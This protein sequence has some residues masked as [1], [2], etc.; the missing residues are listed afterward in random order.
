MASQ[1]S[2]SISEHK[3][4]QLKKRLDS[5]HYCHPLTLDSAALAERLLTDLLKTTEGFQTL[6]KS[7]QDLQTQLLS[8]DKL[9]EPLIKENNRLLQENNELH[10]EMI[11]IKEEADYKENRWKTM[12]KTAEGDKQDI[13][14][15]LKGKETSMQKLIEEV[16][17]FLFLFCII[18]NY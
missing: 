4:L 14:F 2:D 3:F 9:N 13:K 17:F 10:Y 15:L 16:Y 8:K 11:K 1:I 5:L 18:F 7:N 6:K 12:L